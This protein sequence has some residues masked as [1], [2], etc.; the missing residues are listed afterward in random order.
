MQ[1]F[2]G[3]PFTVSILDKQQCAFNKKLLLNHPQMNFEHGEKQ[4][5]ISKESDTL[6]E[7]DGCRN[8]HII[9]RWKEWA[10]NIAI[11]HE[12][13]QQKSSKCHTGNVQIFSFIF[14]RMETI[15]TELFFSI[16]NCSAYTFIFLVNLAYLKFG[17]MKNRHSFNGIESKRGICVVCVCESQCYIWLNF[18]WMNAQ[19][20][21]INLDNQNSHTN[22]YGQVITLSYTH[23]SVYPL[24]FHCCPNCC[25]LPF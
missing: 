13:N 16:S 3:H 24:Q 20:R 19:L 14:G 9:A 6:W 4:K 11:E 22:T 8:V 15:S 17:K 21:L 18:S 5:R 12:L 2:K 25:F 23:Y 1:S 10:S 7:I